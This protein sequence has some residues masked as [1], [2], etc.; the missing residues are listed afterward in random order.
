MTV[1]ATG[2]GGVACRVDR[3]RAAAVR[4]AGVA[5]GVVRVRN[6][7]L[8]VDHAEL[9]GGGEVG[10]PA[11]AAGPIGHSHRTAEVEAA[12][13]AGHCQND[14]R[15]VARG[16]DRARA[17]TIARV[18]QA[19]H[20]APGAH[21]VGQTELVDLLIGANVAVIG[22]FAA[23]IEGRVGPAEHHR[24]DR[25]VAAVEADGLGRAVELVVVGG[26]DEVEAGGDDAEVAHRAAVPVGARASVLI[27]HDCQPSWA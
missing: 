15:V 24:A 22:E 27:S 12:D 16:V 21:Q 18:F 25:T 1:I 23:G 3:K 7:T 5:L 20:D 17:V 13:A 6:H 9:G 8:D 2:P 26:D 19:E 4:T 14:V 10:C 11:R